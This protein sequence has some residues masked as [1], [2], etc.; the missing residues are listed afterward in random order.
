[1]KINRRKFLK[2]SGI[3]TGIALL[4][5]TIFIISIDSKAGKINAAQ[6]D[7]APLPGLDV[8]G[9]GYDATR[10]YAL[11]T[12]RMLRI[13]DLGPNEEI[14]R[15]PNM[16]DYALPRSLKDIVPGDITR[17]ERKVVM[18]QSA[19][20]YQRK[21]CVRAGLSGSY[22]FFSASLK[23]TFSREELA[24][25]NHSF[26]TVL[27]IFKGWEISLPDYS[28]LPMLESAR[29]DIEGTGTPEMPPMEVVKKYG[30]H[31]VVKAVV[32]GRAEYHSIVN[33]SK[34]ASTVSL[35][36][37][38]KASYSGAV[39]I[40]TSFDSKTKKAVKQFQESS[41][42]RI[43]THG[44]EF[45]KELKPSNYFEWQRA[46]RDHPVLIDL[47]EGSLVDIWKLPSKKM[48]QEEL[49]AACEQYVKERQQLFPKNMT[50]LCVRIVS[51]SQVDRVS[52]DKGSGAKMNLSVYRPQVP[53]GWYWVGHSANIKDR[54]VL[55]KS[56]VPGALAEPS[57]YFCAW[58]DAGSGKDHGYSLWNIVAPPGYR[59]LGGIARLRKRR[60]DWN[61]PSGEEVKGLMCVHESLCT[62]GQFSEKLIW[63]DYKTGADKS[64]SVWE[65]IPKGGRGIPARTLYSQESWQ[66]PTEKVYV[67][68]KGDGIEVT[69]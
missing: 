66:K 20:E 43:V 46:L 40:E 67:I 22:G 15:A 52:T 5:G 18:G 39:R 29:R 19:E 38:A 57:G 25:F 64:G 42:I 11:P 35:E 2:I 16:K 47:T 28:K 17:G 69:Q 6:T 49:K 21:L 55:V 1:M 14:K 56:A 54:L 51:K 53:P 10:E 7:L 60:T 65:I 4:V 27:D 62:T 12:S 58:N 9:W 41:S 8:L 30:T 34:Y 37:A 48:R 36:E 33:R 45:Y 50:R 31:V 3:F 13:Y 44:G 68:R 24:S 26:V 23:T 61:E 32:G 63:N 59:A